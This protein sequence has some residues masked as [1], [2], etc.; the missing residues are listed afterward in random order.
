MS[1]SQPPNRHARQPQRLVR[2]R[3]TRLVEAQ[4]DC[5]AHR[6]IWHDRQV[7]VRRPAGLKHAPGRPRRRVRRSETKREG[8]ARRAKRGRSS[9]RTRQAR[10]ATP[11]G[12]VLD[13]PTRRRGPSGGCLKPVG[14]RTATWRSCQIGRWATQSCCASMRRVRR[15]RTRRCGWRACRLGGCARASPRYGGAHGGT[16]HGDCD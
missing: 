8:V 5:V 12:F 9:S 2:C 11:S 6:P 10:R 13:H 4:H 3:L 1:S 16:P 15:H 7:G 14:R